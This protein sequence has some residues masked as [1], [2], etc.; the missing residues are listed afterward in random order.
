MPV[1]KDTFYK[2]LEKIERKPSSVEKTVKRSK[3]QASKRNGKSRVGGVLFAMLVLAGSGAFYYKDKLPPV[4]EELKLKLASLQSFSASD[5]T[6]P[7]GEQKPLIPSVLHE[8][9]LY[10]G[11]Y[12][13][14]AVLSSDGQDYVVTDIVSGF[15]PPAEPLPPKDMKF[16][17]KNSKCEFRTPK[18]SEKVYSVNLDFGL[19]KTQVHTFSDRQINKKLTA[20]L[21]WNMNSDY[22]RKRPM[23]DFIVTGK[24]YSVDVFVTDTKAPVY[25]VLQS[26]S[27]PIIWNVHA[28]KGVKIAHIAINSGGG[29]G[30]VVPK[31]NTSFEAIDYVDFLL[32]KEQKRKTN[33]SKK[34]KKTAKDNTPEPCEARPWR[35]PK[36]HWVQWI[37][38]N[39]NGGV[40][41][42][43][44]DLY[45]EKSRF[46][47]T[48]F[49]SIFNQPAEKNLTEAEAAAHVL[50]GPR[51]KQNIPYHAVA[52]SV[53]HMM[54]VDHVIVAEEAERKKQILAI[55][56][57]AMDRIT[58]GGYD[59]V[60]PGY[61]E[62][63]Q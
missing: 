24:T 9:S 61:I 23:E 10:G 40:Y 41:R 11:L 5:P 22:T 54:R 55:Q 34:N 28:A 50:L 18:R 1:N 6:I 26:T 14:P 20:F 39:N 62:A 57:A 2:R 27:K 21:D 19:S 44:R 52:D 53:V 12:H 45:F 32:T 15:T 43:Q 13:S 17:D 33:S 38:A 60:D 47:D 25:L 46:Y 59:K 7:K 30:V 16:F 31:A 48:W 35:K 29:S 3:K 58:G 4:V 8:A 49:R 42:N 63:E 56:N 36:E 37:K 51:P